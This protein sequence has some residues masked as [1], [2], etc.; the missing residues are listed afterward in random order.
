MCIN[1]T[2]DKFIKY[3]SKI[4]VYIMFKTIDKFKIREDFY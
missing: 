4:Y 3:M 2:I 1:K